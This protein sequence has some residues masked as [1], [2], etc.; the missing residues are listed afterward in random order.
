[1]YWWNGR[2]NMILCALMLIVVFVCMLYFK[3]IYGLM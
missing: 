1:M 2:N 3:S